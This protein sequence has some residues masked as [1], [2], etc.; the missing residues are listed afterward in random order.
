MLFHRALS[1]SALITLLSIP[2]ASS[3]TSNPTPTPSPAVAPS[4]VL[5]E[6]KPLTRKPGY[7]ISLTLPPAWTEL[8]LPGVADLLA[9]GCDA[10]GLVTNPLTP[11]VDE[12][13]ACV[14]LLRSTKVVYWPRKAKGVGLGG[15][16]RSDGE[17]L[18]CFIT[19]L[20]LVACSDPVL[21][22]QLPEEFVSGDGKME[23]RGGADGR[24][25]RIRS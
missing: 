11:W 17:I 20:R 24:R 1:A 23:T 22:A 19:G 2:L 16:G 15:E 21:L 8:C 9:I 13:G 14:I 3:I 7:E 4:A 12:Q 10:E 6:Y 5:A 18:K 25:L